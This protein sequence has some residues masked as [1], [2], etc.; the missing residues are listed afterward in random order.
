MANSGE[1]SS[2]TWYPAKNVFK[3]NTTLLDCDMHA[4]PVMVGSQ[5]Y[6]SFKHEIQRPEDW[7]FGRRTSMNIS[8]GL[9]C[10]YP[11]TVVATSQGVQNIFSKKLD[12][13]FNFKAFSRFALIR[14]SIEL[15]ESDW[16]HLLKYNES[17]PKSNTFFGLFPERVAKFYKIF[18]NR[19]IIGQAAK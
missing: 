16:C 18:G 7:F 9:E 13:N 3:V 8:V 19:T 10:R 4:E 12:R 1:C 14:I 5:K 6:W 17:P 11:A 2:I 15:L